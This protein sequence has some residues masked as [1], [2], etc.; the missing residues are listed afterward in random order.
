[1]NQI[2]QVIKNVVRELYGVVADVIVERPDPQFGDYASN[3]AMQLAGQLKRNPRELA[4]ELAE[5]LTQ[6]DIFQS[7]E[8]AGPGFINLRVTDKFLLTGLSDIL[9]AP[10]SY[11]ASDLYKNKVVVAEYSDPNP[12]KVLHI[13]HLYTSIVGDVIS[14]L[15]EQAGGTVH[16]VNFGGDV[17]LHVAK[18]MWAIIKNL[19]GESP[20]K[21]A[22][23]DKNQRADWLAARYVEGNGAYGADD[24]AQLEIVAL[25]KR[26][27][28]IHTDDDKTS[29]LAQIYWTC[30]QWSYD[31]FNEFYQRVGVKF[32][33]YYPES[34]NAGLGLATVLE[35]TKKGVYQKSNGAIIFDGE[36]F[37]LHAR[38]FVNSEGLPTYEAKDVGVSLKKWQDY[39]FDQSI[40]IT[41]NDIIEYMKVVIKSIEQFAPQ[42]A[43]RTLHFTHGNVKLAGGVKMSSRLGNFVRAVDVLDFTTQAQ[44]AA[45]GNDNQ[46]TVLAAVRYS[47]L[48]N[49]IGPDIMF[50]PETSVSLR[51]NSG[52]YL[53][54]ALT[55]AKA[56]LRK[57]QP[58]PAKKS[59]QIS[60][61]EQFER[62]L[63]IKLQDFPAT[64]TQATKELAPH[65]VCTYLYELAQILNRFYEN[66]HV[67][68]DP[69]EALRAQLVQAYATVLAR[70][71]G[72]LGIETLEKM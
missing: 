26:I 69:R 70:G 46:A 58:Q 54:Y 57:V 59:S 65:L 19:G 31:Y 30:R 28:Q 44:Q 34:E 60:Q 40:I 2:A 21:L 41:A 66:S 32:E 7:A 9:S 3:V 17:G 23:V 51:G 52:P 22:Q 29:A 68:G 1:M 33:K 12:F 16:R 67:A 38:V 24:E 11:G 71:L 48:K 25:N 56:I 35:Q 4:E 55:R 13:G 63:A 72:I 37:G 5:K 8:V 39:H 6:Q 14:N 15:I 18:S 53:Q 50:D 64:L 43:Q 20:K 27:Y 47:F 10:D 49:S 36:P 62:D 42:P 45:Q 61:L